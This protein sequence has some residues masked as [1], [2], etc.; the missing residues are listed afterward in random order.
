M[1]SL[2]RSSFTRSRPMG[3]GVVEPFTRRAKLLLFQGKIS[4]I[5]FSWTRQVLWIR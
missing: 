2:R 5:Y 3:R 4:W 1:F